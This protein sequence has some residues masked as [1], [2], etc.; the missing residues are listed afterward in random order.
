MQIIIEIKS[1]TTAIKKQTVKPNPI[2]SPN[3][4][5]INITTVTMK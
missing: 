1:I 2:M 5:T 3:Q 4:K